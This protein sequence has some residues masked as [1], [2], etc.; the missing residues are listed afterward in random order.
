VVAPRDLEHLRAEVQANHAPGHA[1]DSRQLCGQLAR[2]ARDVERGAAWLEARG[3]RGPPPPPSV[4][5]TRQ[6]GVDQ[7][8]PPRDAVEHRTHGLGV[9]L[10]D[11]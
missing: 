4:G 10:G 7:V 8:I 9:T 2:A 1:G 5:A 3:P 11:R 6:D